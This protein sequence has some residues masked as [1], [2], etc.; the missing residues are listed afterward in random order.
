LSTLRGADWGI[1]YA[2]DEDIFNILASFFAWDHPCR[3]F[4]DEHI[5]LD[6]LVDGGSEFCSSLL[7]HTVL[8]YGAKNYAFENSAVADSVEHFA[9]VQAKTIFAFEAGHDT[10]ATI[11]AGIM[12]HIIYLVNGDDKAGH[13]YLAQA[14]KMGQNIGLFDVKSASSGPNEQLRARGLSVLAWGLFAHQSLVFLPLY[15]QI[16]LIVCHRSISL[17]MHET[18]LIADTPKVE[19]TFNDSSFEEDLWE[20]YPRH[21]PAKQSLTNSIFAAR[22]SLYAIVNGMI[23]LHKKFESHRLSHVY[24]QGLKV[25][26]EQLNDWYNTLAFPLA[27]LANAT[28]HHLALQ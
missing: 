1:T 2:D 7:L 21:V 9:L 22:A 20:A 19:K 11:A 8:A 26:A 25:I 12:I 16:M 24:L 10:P 15:L 3:R 27:Y 5:F 13:Q 4:F 28:P 18:P 17:N 23:P 14:V 6:G